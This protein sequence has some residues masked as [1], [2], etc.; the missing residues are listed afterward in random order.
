M[1]VPVR[2]L[3]RNEG[4]VAAPILRLAAEYTG[5]EGPVLARFVLTRSAAF[6]AGFIFTTAPLAPGQELTIDGFVVMPRLLSSTQARQSVP[7]RIRADYCEDERRTLQTA[8]PVY[9]RVDEF[10]ETNNVSPDITVRL[11]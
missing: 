5:R 4:N 7:F 11:P 8:L 3:V 2:L 9:C 6:T 10:S 1:R